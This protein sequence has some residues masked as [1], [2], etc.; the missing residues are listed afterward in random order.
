MNFSLG[1]MTPFY[2]IVYDHSGLSNS[3]IE[4]IKE[5]YKQS[6]IETATVDKNVDNPDI[7]RSEVV[8]MNH[9]FANE[10]GVHDLI[11]K[12]YK[13]INYLNESTFK[14]NLLDV[15]PFQITRYDESNNGFYNSHIDSGTFQGNITRKL[16][17]VIQLS[18][19]SDFEGGS[20]IYHNSNEKINLSEKNPEAVQK[21][22]I[23][24]FPSFVPH[25]VTPVTKGTRYSLVGWCI[26]E[27]F[28]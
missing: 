10:F 20:F 28:K 9:E 19:P 14:F 16:S 5:Y 26:G 3:E 13:T 24:V 23:I 22:N 2:D 1:E 4:A 27:R 25:G 17:F 8:W 6:E 11:S 18:D 12:I 21:G 15:E 7:R